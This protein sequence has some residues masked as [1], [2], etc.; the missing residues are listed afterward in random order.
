[1]K[2]T[3]HPWSAQRRPRGEDTRYRR[4]TR[5]GQLLLSSAPP[6]SSVSLP[7]LVLT[8]LSAAHSATV[9]PV[10]KRQSGG[11][12]RAPGLV[13]CLLYCLTA[14]YSHRMNFSH[15]HP[16]PLSSPFPPPVE[17]FLL[18]KCW[19]PPPQPPL[20][21]RL[22][23][24]FLCGAALSHGQE[25]VFLGQWQLTGVHST[26]ESD[27]PFS[28]TETGQK[29]SGSVGSRGPARSTRSGAVPRD[30]A[31]ITTAEVSVRRQG[32]CLLSGRVMF[33]DSQ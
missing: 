20:P 28:A 16:F 2:N 8:K 26:E 22:S 6:P 12:L 31:L 18:S 4:D 7:L 33:S 13:V 11:H 25:A 21:S 5:L 17:H 3:Q 15:A 19:P 27:F 32:L 30:P 29:A 23:C 14:S 1:M 10:A 24:L 9:S